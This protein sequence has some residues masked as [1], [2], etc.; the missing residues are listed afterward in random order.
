VIDG[1]LTMG[2]LVAFQSLMASFMLPVSRLVGLGGK[3]Q[4]AE[5][6]LSRLD[7]VL[8]YPQDPF[9]V[10]AD[11]TSPPAAGPKLEGYLELRNVTFGY[12]RFDPPLI[13]NFSLSASP[14]HRVALVGGSGSGKSTVAKLVAGL[15][16][17]WEGEILFDGIRRDDWPREVLTGSVA[18]VDQDISL[19][20][21]TI[22]ANLTMWDETAEEPDIVRAA[23]DACVHD[24]I[25]DRPGGYDYPVEEQGRN[26]SGGQRQR[27][28]IARALAV[29]PRV[30]I[31]DEA[32]SALDPLTEKIVDDNI[33]RRGCTCLVVAHRLSTV[34]D[35][36][37]IVVLEK[38]QVVERGTHVE[39]LQRDGTYAR[40]IRST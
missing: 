26:F 32:T 3:L 12:S 33:R 34:R 17:P 30:L 8:H 5:G 38:G 31:L 25:T 10:E 15:Y 6:S 24:D 37:E 21:G 1:I 16:R 29:N 19:F 27:L 40:L 11:S 36:D 7:D 28:E 2:M 20:D 23:V 18:L 39:L 13:T 35:C 22:G 9:A 14:G 4:E